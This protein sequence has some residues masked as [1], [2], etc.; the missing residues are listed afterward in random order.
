M[1]FLRGGF[2]DGWQGYHYCRLIASYEYMIVIKMRELQ[3][4][5]LG[6]SI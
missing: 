4:R 1:Y 2:L 6:L 3:R 5:E